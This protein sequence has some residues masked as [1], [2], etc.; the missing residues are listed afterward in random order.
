MDVYVLE[1]LVK[2]GLPQREIATILGT[3]Q[4]NVRYWIKKLNLSRSAL[5]GP[6]TRRCPKCLTHLP[7]TNFYGRRG[8]NGNSTYC[9]KCTTIQ[10]VERQH[11]LK[12]ELIDY[13]GGKCSRCGYCKCN[14]ALEFHHIDPFHKEFNISKVKLTTFNQ[15]I[16]N[17][18]DKCI[19][20]CANCHREVHQELGLSSKG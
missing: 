2:E 19:L 16:K 1:V 11:R 8:K 4:T 15:Q 20:L 9:K 14:S 10:V 3:S 7:L 6:V 18:L 13:M 17:E 5:D 12:Q